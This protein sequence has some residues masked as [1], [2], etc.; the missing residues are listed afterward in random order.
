MKHLLTILLFL[1]T[2]FACAQKNQTDMTYARDWQ[3]A[4]SLAKK[5]LPKSALAIVDAIYARAKAAHNDPQVVKA[6]MYRLVYQSYTTEDT[7][8]EVIESLRG[9]VAETSAPARNILQSILAETYWQYYE[10]NRWKFADRK[11][12]AALSDNPRTWDLRRLVAETIAAYEV[13]V[14]QT[15]LLKKTPVSAFEVVVRKGD[16]DA[17]PLRPTLYDFLAHRALAFYTNTEPD[18]IRPANRF[19]LDQPTY[20]ADAATF[21]NAKL[22]SS[23]SLSL[24]FRALALYQELLQFHRAGAPTNPL[25]LADVDAARLAF[26]HQYSTVADKDKLYQQTLETEIK[27]HKNQPAE[28]FYGLALAELWADLGDK[29]KT[30]NHRRRA[31]E[32]A[33]DLLKR[34]PKAGLETKNA[35]RLLDRLNVRSLNLTVEEGNAPDQPNRA[36]VSYRSVPTLHYRI[37][38]VGIDDQARIDRRNNGDDS[39]RLTR[40]YLNRPVVKEGT[41]SLP[42]DGDL[43]EHRTEIALPALPLGHYVVLTAPDA[44]MTD[45]TELLSYTHLV[46]TNLGYL[47][48]RR[49][50][51]MQK[52][53]KGD[54]IDDQT[55]VNDPKLYVMNRQTGQPLANVRVDIIENY[56]TGN[57]YQQHNTGSFRTDAQGGFALS[58]ADVSN[59]HRYQ[60][61]IITQKDT[62]ET[63]SQYTGYRNYGQQSDENVIRVLLFTDRAIYRP[64]QTIF[65]KGVLYKGKDNDFRVAANEKT[66]AI[67]TDVNGEKVASLPL[68]SNDFGTVDGQ[69]TA[70][71]GRLTGGMTITIAGGGTTVRVEEYK[72]PTFEVTVKPVAGSYKLGQ[73]VSVSAT[74]KTFAG[75]V[76]DGASVRYRVVRRLRPRWIWW[77]WGGYMSSHR[78]VPNSGPE[79]EIESGTLTTD[80]TGAVSLTFVAQPDPTVDRATNPTFNFT[81]FFAVT[82][83]TGET[84]SAEQPLNIGYSALT[85]TL[86]LPAEVENHDRTAVLRVTNAGGQSVPVTGQLIVS[87]LQPPAHQLRPRLWEKPDRFALSREAFKKLFPNDV[88]ADEDQIPNWPK[89]QPIETVPIGASDTLK[90]DLSRCPAG[91]YAADVRVTDASGES[92]TLTQYFTVTTDAQPLPAALP[93][94]WVKAIKTEVKPGGSAAFLLTN[95]DLGTTGQALM[96]VVQ[97]GIVRQERWIIIAE[98]PVRVEV[99]VTDAQIGGFVVSFTKV[100]NGRVYDLSKSIAV[101]MPD[102]ELRIETLT[103]R[104]HLKPGQ[105]EQW[106]LRISGPDKEKFVAEMVATLY[107]ASLDAFVPLRWPTSP[108][109]AL[110]NPVPQWLASAFNTL[111]SSMFRYDY[112]DTQPIKRQYDALSWV[113]ND[114][115][116]AVPVAYMSMSYGIGSDSYALNETVSVGY[117]QPRGVAGAAPM[118]MS[119]KKM[120]MAVEAKP[121]EERPELDQAATAEFVNPNKP[122]MSNPRRNFSETA[123][124]FPKLQTDEQ[125]RVLLNFTMPEALTRWRLLAFAHTPDLKTGSL[126]RT[127]VTQKELMI[128]ANAPRFLR[129]GDTLRLTA[130][131]NNL[132]DRPLYGAAN[133][134]V[135]DARTGQ[136]LND[137]MGQLPGESLMIAPGI[138]QT[139][140]WTLAVPPGASTPGLENVTFRVSATAGQFTDAEERTVPVLPNRI[141][142]LDSQPFYVNGNQ[143]KTVRLDALAKHAPELPLSAERL[144]VELTGNPVWTALQSLPYLTEFPYECAEQLFSRF[145]ANALASRI[146][147]A[148]PDIRAVA[149]TWAKQAPANPLETNAEL[150]S[151]TL[152]ETPWR[153][154]ARSQTKQQAQIGQFLK[155]D[156]LIAGQQAALEKLQ[157]LQNG[158][159]GFMWFS[160]MPIDRTIS[161]HIL[162]GFGHLAKLGVALPT[163]QQ[164]IAGDMK[165]RA[166][167][168][169]DEEA[170]QW[171]ERQKREKSAGYGGYRAVQY[172]YARSFYPERPIADKAVRDYLQTAIAK[173]WLSQSLNEQA[174]IALA[175]HRM[176]DRQTPVAILKSLKERAATSDEMGMYWP[177][178]RVGY[179]WQQA[180]IETQ[181]L[182]IEAFTEIANDANAVEAMKHWLLNQKRTNAWPST[183]ATTEAIY[184]LLLNGDDWLN[185]KSTTELQIGG[186]VIE[187]KANGPTG[188]QK[189]TYQPAD[190]KP[191]MGVVTVS[192]TGSGPA[193]GGIYYQHFEPLDRVTPSSEVKEARGNLTL[194]KQLFVQHDSPAGPVSTPVTDKTKL[195]PGDKLL[196]RVEVRNDRDMQYVHLKDSRASGFEPVDALSGYKYQNGLGYYEAPRDASTDFFLS[197]LPAG[198]HVFEYGLRVVHTGDFSTGIATIQCFYAPE[199]AARSAGSRVF[200]A[201]PV[202]SR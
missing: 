144:T 65:F 123:F 5:G 138:S 14:N 103:F 99:P 169:A 13:S 182:L 142:V 48:G 113:K 59:N 71:V 181:A 180:P 49:P 47:I 93:N 163:K 175:L 77:E 115:R 26:V 40:Q 178:N 97:E 46:V 131:V 89:G 22:V 32:L 7:Y 146:V 116:G 196:V 8:A 132:T 39:K 57:S 174:L 38:R 19:T 20:L 173:D 199:F 85:A 150:K 167:Q 147:N 80:A 78:G 141:L 45:A 145:Y 76:V 127:V 15:D 36:S 54:V 12:D 27:Q 84:R 88:Y 28:I 112:R 79:T 105:P 98:K 185:T 158:S 188:Y 191:E 122:I 52:T 34:F 157:Q 58:D 139:V 162:A 168:F 197:H 33:T 69:F 21:A 184:A 129:E 37:V 74:A 30:G 24:K 4:D 70:P 128:S 16:Q 166:L 111:R 60:F 73:P 53:A 91:V 3:R 187:A 62:L 109:Q 86:D 140:A 189:V 160:G 56:Y 195:K 183:K 193:W 126:D 63:E 192:K 125:G 164:Q 198:T 194:T 176:G 96:R 107:D 120:E 159:G 121:D 170:R 51:P 31:A 117:G 202:S 29:T 114:Y 104:D 130:R 165:N 95:A 108:Y 156:N 154:A 44:P 133:L 134:Q 75:A 92:A 2:A 9:D 135:F 161:L 101:P 43:Q 82:D 83:R 50:V 18:I 190:I 143:T 67:L 64:G 90:L 124:F 155:D 41:V 68:T 179:Y 81:V 171:V 6:A 17:R 10:Q 153:R 100:Q 35:E 172:L 110:Y 118:R 152:D 11:T 186:Q 106:T 151:V 119:A 1:T 102:K 148:R 66:E 201:T 94:N 25:A 87:P 137:K 42:D 200:V 72:R 23:D 55:L 136:S 61:R 177:D 149:E